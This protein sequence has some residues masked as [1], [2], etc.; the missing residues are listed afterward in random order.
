MTLHLSLVRPE[1]VCPPASLVCIHAKA[2]SDDLPV[3]DD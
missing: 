1:S 2:L 3:E